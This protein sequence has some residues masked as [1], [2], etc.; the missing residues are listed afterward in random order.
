MSMKS[1]PNCAAKNAKAARYCSQCSAAIVQGSAS[2]T[3]TKG[4]T[5]QTPKKKGGG[6]FW[7]VLGGI[8]VVGGVTAQ[9][10]GSTTTSPRVAQASTPSPEQ[11]A[12][13]EKE[14][15]I[16]LIVPSDPKA[17]YHVLKVEP[18]PKGLIYIQSSRE[19]P[20]GVSFSERQV[21]CS[22]KSFAYTRE[23]DTLEAL[24]AEQR[25]PDPM[26]PRVK[27]SI[28]DVVSQY[29]CDHPPEA[30]KV[31]EEREAETPT[32]AAIRSG[33]EM[34]A[35]QKASTDKDE[36]W[37]VITQ[38]AVR[39]SVRDPSSAT[40]RN[41]KLYRP[42]SGQDTP[43]VCG[44]VNS[45]NGFGGMSGFQ[46]FIGSGSGESFPIILEEQMAAGEYAESA[47]QLCVD[48]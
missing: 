45:K 40:F 32:N 47:R 9:G 27:G 18:G 44:E 13:P 17:T 28:S 33:G 24:L 31:S 38:D 42:F 4:V 7:V 1:C 6:I 22:A 35:T 3:P 21:N 2:V 11:V 48:A 34:Q 14:Q 8:A 46:G 10:G 19:G 39:R 5:A 41:V 30:R 29:A 25:K 12:V 26:G 20:S 37:T 15:G 43:V 36:L 23:G 16:A